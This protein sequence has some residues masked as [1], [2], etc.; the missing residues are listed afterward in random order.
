MPLTFYSCPPGPALRSE[1]RVAAAPRKTN[2]RRSALPLLLSVLLAGPAL[3][4][5]AADGAPLFKVK[6]TA[7]HTQQKVLDGVRK[8]P[9]R[10]RRAQLDRFLTGHYAPDAAQ[11]KAI[12]DHLIAAAGGE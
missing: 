1:R 11:R 7:C 9:E 2:A 6:C 4:Q 8:L 5:G 12:C 3:G 10:D